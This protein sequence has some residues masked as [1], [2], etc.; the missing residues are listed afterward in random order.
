[1]RILYWI[2]KFFKNRITPEYLL[3]SALRQC[4]WG[5]VIELSQ[6]Y[7]E[8]AVGWQVYDCLTKKKISVLS[9]AVRVGLPELV[10]E[11]IVLGADIHEKDDNGNTLLH[12]LSQR[13]GRDEEFGGEQF[14]ECARV[15]IET[16]SKFG[17]FKINSLNE[18]GFNAIGLL[19]KMAKQNEQSK[20][21]SPLKGQ[22]AL[23]LKFS[24][25]GEN[26]G[27]GK[28]MCRALDYLNEEMLF[29]TL[30]LSEENNLTSLHLGAFGRI[31]AIADQKMDGKVSI[32]KN[33]SGWW[34]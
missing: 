23:I 28:K 32:S 16:K 13:I 5:K 2:R 4:N 18:D 14:I 15:L 34:L 17:P 25:L 21:I 19:A 26:P 27:V 6:K 1:M 30:A 11:L 10:K 12:Q 29:K 22:Y 9:F 7:P 20:N 24:E 33:Y 3:S 8:V 31:R